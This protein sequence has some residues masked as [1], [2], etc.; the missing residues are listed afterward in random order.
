MDL[1]EA[2]RIST[3]DRAT[4]VHEVLACAAAGDAFVKAGALAWL[5]E[6]LPS[7]VELWPRIA[8]ACATHLG[9]FKDEMF[10]ESVDVVDKSLTAKREAF[11]QACTRPGRVNALFVS[12]TGR[13]AV[14]PLVIRSAAWQQA[15]VGMHFQLRDQQSNEVF[16]G[17]ISKG[18]L[19]AEAWLLGKRCSPS[20]DDFLLLRTHWREAAFPT[21]PETAVVDG[22]SIGL[23]SA[24]A[25]VA[26]L[27]NLPVSAECAFTGTIDTEGRVGPVDGVPAKVAAAR[28]VGIS[29]VFVPGG[30][31]AGRE[32][33]H[34]VV[35][36]HCLDDVLT[37]V[38]SGSLDTHIR[39]LFGIKRPAHYADV[40]LV[41]F[42]TTPRRVVLFSAVGT[43]DPFGFI[44]DEHGRAIRHTSDEGP[45]LSI[46]R[47]VKPSALCLAFT[48]SQA[49]K[50]SDMASAAERTKQSVVTQG[51][52]DEAHVKL[53]PMAEVNP[54]DYATVSDGFD[55]AVTKAI[56]A[57][58]VTQDDIILI[59]GTSGTPTMITCWVLMRM[60]LQRMGFRDVAILQS[61]EA[62]FAKGHPFVVRNASVGI[63]SALARATS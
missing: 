28:H 58:V 27:L 15:S 59:N 43:S 33:P 44:K 32:A 4:A 19:A 49:S 21:L 29:K 54:T 7:C 56:D 60:K 38:F 16:R 37:K 39:S 35:E 55:R 47:V 1:E 63:D 46:C 12:S 34:D 23:A 20:P 36:V 40:D 45:I 3:F 11:E 51:L 62:E 18:A 10:K 31:F 2:T 50:K 6:H 52:M 22:A 14:H 42:I 48:T 26:S 57:R 25:N 17:A 30:S 5:N 41:G 53:Y 61:V 13:G 24:V 8:D 9:T